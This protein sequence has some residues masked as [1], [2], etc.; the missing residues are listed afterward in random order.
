MFGEVAIVRLVWTLTV[1]RKEPPVKATTDEPGI[2]IFRR[3]PDG[4]WKITRFTAYDLPP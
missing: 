1:E 4:K 2:D 3:Q